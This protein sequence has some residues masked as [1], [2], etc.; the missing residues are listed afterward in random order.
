LSLY[1]ARRSLYL[2]PPLWVTP[3]ATADLNF[4]SGRYYTQSDTHSISD[5]I[6]NSRSTVAM[7]QWADGHWSTFGVGV[8]CITDL[9]LWSW[10]AATNTALWSRDMTQ[11]VWAKVNMTAALTATGIDGASNS[12][13]TLT[14]TAANAT[15]LQTL[16]L[17]SQAETYSVFLKRVSGSGIINI[18]ENGGTSWTPVVLTSAWQR[19]NV[20]AILAN[21]VIGIQIVTNGDVIA[22]DFNQNEA[23]TFPTPPILT[24]NAAASRSADV[25]MAQGALANL[26][27]YPTI[28]QI[29]TQASG[30]IGRIWSVGSYAYYMSTYAAPQTFPFAISATSGQ[31]AY[32]KITTNNAAPV[33]INWGDGTSITASSG[34][35]YN[36]TYSGSFSG[37]VSVTTQAGSSVTQWSSSQGTASWAFNLSALPYGITLVGI[38]GSNTVS[39]NLSSIPNATYVSIYGSNT[40]SGNLSSIPNA[41]IVN[42]QGSNTVS[43]NLS[44]IPNATNVGIGGSNTVSGNLSSIPNATYVSIGGSNT[45]TFSGSWVGPTTNMREVYMR[46]TAAL[47]STVCDTLL[48]ALAA[49]VTSWTNEKTVNLHGSRTSASNAAV[50]TLNGL[51]VTVTVN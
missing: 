49:S 6:S 36:H 14:A 46:S 43:G 41:T 26:S 9:G 28:Q 47:S 5:L 22:A 10:Q 34:T 33:T 50:A 27:A 13:S 44:S 37:N 4:A 25:I 7:A 16:T 21:P 42:I 3:N 19:F 1:R 11:S 30:A 38:G 8:P 24:T 39:G 23:N 51:G 40:V 35:E 12:A 17:S 18:T 15:I 20:E 48:N 45:T 2:Q 31:S 29:L 32:L